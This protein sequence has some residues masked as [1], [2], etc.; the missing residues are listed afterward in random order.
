M[1]ATTTTTSSATSAASAGAAAARTATSRWRLLRTTPLRDVF[2][3]RLTGRLD[4]AGLIAAADLPAAVADVVQQTVRRARLGRLERADLAEELIA[5]FQDGLEAGAAAEALVAR[6][7]DPRRAARLMRRARKRNRTPQEQIIMRA[8]QSLIV[9]LGIVLLGYGLLALRYFTG[10]ANISTDYLAKYRQSAT[11][12]PPEERAWP[13]Y[14]AAHL[15]IEKGEHRFRRWLRPGDDGWEETV[16]LLKIHAASIE[17]VRQAAKKPA[18]GYVPDYKVAPEDLPILG[19]TASEAATAQASADYRSYS[20][21]DVLLPHFGPLRQ[22]AKC[23][24]ADLRL[25]ALEG[26]A[27]RATDNALAGLALGTH[28][29]GTPFLIADLVAYAIWSLTCNDLQAVLTEQPDLFTD[30]QLVALAHALAAIGDNGQPRLHLEGERDVFHDMVQRLYTDDGHGNGRLTAAGVDLL[31][32]YADLSDWD[33]PFSAVSGPVMAVVVADRREMTRKHA[34][35]FNLAEAELH[36]PYHRRPKPTTMEVRLEEI[37]ASPTLRTRYIL[38]ATLM[39]ALSRAA[40]HT[41][42]ITQKRDG[43]LVAVALERYRRD[44]GAYPASL[45]ALVPAYLPAVPLD[46]CTGRPLLYR[47]AGGLPLVYST[48]PDGD[49]DGGRLPDRVLGDGIGIW[50]DQY[51]SPGEPNPNDGDWLLFPQPQRHP[52]LDDPDDNY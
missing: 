23:V 12:A 9:L 35:L 2:R 38:I 30:E 17:Q 47:L 8:L 16:A 24:T 51:P 46:R 6:F 19:E 14:R 45:D 4:V 48:G 39:P 50:Q 5:H 31:T 28:A 20:L 36:L 37:V 41:D 21:I 10:D 11:A 1:N 22:L 52:V 13:D 40:F 34:E 18:L 29:Q 49:D 3:F 32:S 7:G 42:M 26:D 25:A 43:L 44:R 27:R 15:A 33:E